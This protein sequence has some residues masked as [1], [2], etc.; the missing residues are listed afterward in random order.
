MMLL[1]A[2]A[3]MG[4]KT[5]KAVLKSRSKRGSGVLANANPPLIYAAYKDKPN[6]IRIL[7][8]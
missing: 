7:L 2:G 5:K 6:C 3:E 1:E 4:T 8:E